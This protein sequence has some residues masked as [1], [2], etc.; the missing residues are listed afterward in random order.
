MCV[1]SKNKPK[2]IPAA[3]TAGS[4]I[5]FFTQVIHRVFHTLFDAGNHLDIFCIGFFT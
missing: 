3:E 2:N 5:P 4:K 1:L